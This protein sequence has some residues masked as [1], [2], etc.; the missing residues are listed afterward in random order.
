MR[1]RGGYHLHA[2]MFPIVDMQI[3]S[4]HRN[5]KSLRDRGTP[6]MEG[7]KKAQLLKSLNEYNYVQ[8]GAAYQQENG[9]ENLCREEPG[10]L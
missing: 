6:A 1:Q 2:K 9:R 7:W 5:M 10:K 8:A 3:I 4:A